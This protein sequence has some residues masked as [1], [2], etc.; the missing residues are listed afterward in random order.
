M[1]S[2]QHGS[3]DN[4]VRRTPAP[5]KKKK[6]HSKAF[7]IFKK[8]MT[9]IAT[10]LLSL[11][12]VI[13][14]TGTI[15][16]TALTVYVLNFM[17]DSTNVTLQQLESG[18]DTYFYGNQ[19]NEAGEKE[20]VQIHTIQNDFQRIPVDIERIPQH[21][22]N[23]FV[24]TEDERFY[25]H[26]GVDYK[27]TFSAFANMFLHFYDTEQG[28]ST[29]T[30]QLVKNLSGDDEHT[31]Q[32]KIRE[33]FS[34][35]QLEKTYS[36]DEILEEYLNYIGFGGPINGIQLASIRYFGKN[37]EQLTV[38]EAAVLAAIP[39]SPEEYGP[40][41]EYHRDN[42]PKE[43]VVIN[44]RANNKPR[45]EYV[46]YKLYE[47]G[48]ITFD[49]YQQYLKAPLLYTDSEEFKKLHP[50]YD[51]KKLEEKEKAYSWIVDATYYEAVDIFMEK[52]D[53]DYSQA[54]N[55]IQKGGYKVY[56]TYDD[57]MQ[58]YIEDKMLDLHNFYP[59]YAPEINGYSADIEPLNHPDGT[60]EIYYPHVAFV[61]LN[62]DGEVLC[63]VG[64]VGPKEDSL[65][66]NYAV[67][68]RRQVGSTIKPLT[69]YGY[70]IETGKLCWGTGIKDA[71]IM[72]GEDG[73]PW[74]LNYG[75]QAGYGGNV[76]AYMALQQSYNTCSAQLVDQYGLEEVYKFSKEKLG[77]DLASLDK[78]YSPLSLGALDYGVTLE[79][80]VNAY[81][82]YGNNGIYNEA[83]IISRIEDSNQQVIYQNNGNPR[84]A[85]SDETAYV[86]NRLLKNVVDHGTGT[87]ARLSNKEV[88]G[89]TGTTQDWYDEAFVGL[90]PDFVSGITVGFKYK[91]GQ[92]QVTSGISAQVWQNLIGEYANTMYPETGPYFEK[93]KT[94]IESPMCTSTGRIAGQYCPRGI[95]G[96]WKSQVTDTYSPPYC[97]GAH[98]YTPSTQATTSASDAQGGGAAGGGD[99]GGG[100]AGG[101]DVGGG[102]AGGGDVGGGAAGGVDIGGGAAGGGDV[103]GGAAG[104]GDVGGGAAGG[105]AGGGV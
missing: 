104:G 28:G 89:K 10:T 43:P 44:G 3:A 11:L 86:M 57:K 47:N 34:A 83:H 19:T 87:A 58:K 78:L 18:S 14:I 13:I 1:A 6:K 101:V 81:L 35:M 8:L 66:S 9:V 79:N 40:F 62:Y 60:P 22:R 46:L 17:D 68:D 42:D 32:R 88:C 103:G 15:V 102:A 21:V 100:A 71:G 51:A 38:P 59:Y 45:Q 16:S 84:Q 92:I 105:D 97:D 25:V 91:Y 30:Q 2:H 53:L 33:I 98:G 64:N 82:P 31:P 50:E 55:K 56:T 65:V 93:V 5:K 69:G 54:M 12:L 61:A 75:K 52:Y 70:G 80:L 20:L 72:T 85:V 26:D 96:Y 94:V 37:V 63:A 39:K 7:I 77:L 99:V 76:M 27:R 36:K 29:I 23:A 74:P 4:E 41:V 73:N 24:Y 48:A 90:T 49:E 67:R 95:I